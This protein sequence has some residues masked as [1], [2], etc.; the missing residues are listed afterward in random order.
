MH[1][2]E[3]EPYSI[4]VTGSYFDILNRKKC[5]IIKITS[6]EFEPLGLICYVLEQP[7]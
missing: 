4:Q 5:D 2:S 6:L 7:A 3:I 1:N